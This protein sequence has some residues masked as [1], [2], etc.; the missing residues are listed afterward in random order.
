M[1]T[2]K[3]IAVKADVSIATVSRILSGNKTY[4]FSQATIDRV[5]NAAA[6]LNYGPPRKKKQK[7]EPAA[8]SG[9]TIAAVFWFEEA[10]EEDYL[11]YREIRRGMERRFA[12]EAISFS[13]YYSLKH[14]PENADG[15][16]AVGKF[17]AAEVERLSAITSHL[18][19][20]DSSPDP[21]AYSSVTADFFDAMKSIIRYL[22]GTGHKKIGYIGKKE[23][24][25]DG[26]EEYPDLKEESYKLIAIAE[27]IYHPDYLYV[28]EDP[29]PSAGFKIASHSM[30][31][32]MPDAFIVFSDT[33]AIGV[34]SAFQEAGVKIPGDVSI[35][36]FDDLPIAQYTFPSLSTVKIHTEHMGASAVDLLMG[37][38]SEKTDFPR[39]VVIPYEIMIRNSSR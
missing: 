24:V 33:V 28:I 6:E 30:T 11:Y 18:V 15:I 29:T 35:I 38:L 31:E 19:F 26:S 1:T 7:Q 20:V 22:I 9:L 17:S 39:K 34:L 4:T 8:A 37:E 3:D 2:I 12:G 21:L 27:G 13:S 36:S 16:I 32:N 14:L 23:Y 10:Q 25:G 5:R